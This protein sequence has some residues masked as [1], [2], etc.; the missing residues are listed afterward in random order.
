MFI[1]QV[2]QQSAWPF[3][4]QIQ[5]IKPISMN[6]KG[7]KCVLILKYLQRQTTCLI[8]ANETKKYFINYIKRTKRYGI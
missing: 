5:K 6:N 4:K 8:F 1:A 7:F 3:P 2:K